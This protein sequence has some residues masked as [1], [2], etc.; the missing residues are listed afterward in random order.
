MRPPSIL[1]GASIKPMTE[2]PVTDLPEP[3]SPARPR[4]SP[5]ASVNDTPSTA[6]AMPSRAWN[7]VRSSCTSS[8]AVTLIS[9]RHVRDQEV[10]P[11]LAERH[12]AHRRHPVH[13]Q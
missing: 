3:D 10:A 5:S 9:K 8:S 12:E 7:Q 4:I 1:P 13:A 6:L 2:S 11:E